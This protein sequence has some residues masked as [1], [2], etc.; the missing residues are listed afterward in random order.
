MPRV[1]IADLVRETGLSR[2]TVDRALNRRGSVHP[3]T[4]ALVEDA[5][6]R[7]ARPAAAADQPRPPVDLVL[8]VGRGMLR[9]LERA[10]QGGGFEGTFHDLHGAGDGLVLER[11]RQLCEAVERPLVVTAKNTDAL[12]ETLR[13]ARARGK[14][15]VALVSDLSPE[16][17]DAFVGID[18]RA[19]GRT[20]AYLVGRM[21]GDRPARVGVVV[22]DPAFR[23]HEDREIGF[24][25]ALRAHFPK[26]VLAGEA[27]G[28]DRAETT[29][30]AVA[31][32]LAREP[33]L[34]AI[35]NV[36][37]GNAGLA[38][39]LRASGR[40]G[41]ILVVAHEVNASTLPLLREGLLAFALAADP[42]V[43]LAEAVRLA[44]APASEAP[45]TVRLL[46]FAVY[47]PFNPPR[48]AGWPGG[49]QVALVEPGIDVF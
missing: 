8:R 13:A 34:A 2:S 4:R 24:R 29:R 49:R 10:W 15:V 21:L 30:S 45:R 19:A 44:T 33:D 28:E 1:R 41:R 31:A 42:A 40:A 5:W 18:D 22:G 37:G 9:Q 39:A 43:Q 36:G 12:V 32:M 48:Q 17:R 11:V 46:D 7:L 26:L 6:R 3:R 23:C 16:A 20:A 25:T 14:R 27:Q 35:Y 47:T 38:E